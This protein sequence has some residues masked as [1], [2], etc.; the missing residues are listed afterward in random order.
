MNRTTK[1]PITPHTISVLMIVGVICAFVAAT[2]GNTATTY[3]ESRPGGNVTDSVVRAVD[4]A[5]PS[6]VRIITTVPGHLIVRFPQG[7]DVTFPQPNSQSKNLIN[8]NAYALQL[9][10]SGTFIT[11][12]GDIVTADHV[13]NPPQQDLAQFLD[14]VAAPD[15]ADYIN[16]NPKTGMAQTTP[17]QVLQQ[18]GSDTLKSTATFS[19]PASEV[20]LSTDYTGPL[21]APDFR[22]IPAEIHA[23]VDKIE[24]ESPIDQKDIAI[25]HAPFTDTPS[26]QLGDSS[27]VQQQDELTIIG[28]PGN[29]DVSNKPTD[30]LTSSVNRI[31]VSSIKSTDNGAP[32]IQVGGNVE[33][34]DS[35]G[36][37]LDSKGTVVGIVSFGLSSSNSIGGT[38]F[39]QASN[40]AR[41]FVQ[42]LNLDTTPGQFQKQ[43]S[44]A[45]TSYASNT[46]GHW[47]QAQLQ[48]TQL[49]SNYPQFKAIKPYMDYTATQAKTEKAVVQPTPRAAGAA[50]PPVQLPTTLSQIPAMAWTIGTVVV[51][52]L[53]SGLLFGVAVRQRKKKPD[54]N[55]PQA[56]VPSAVA[57]AAGHTAGHTHAPQAPQVQGQQVHPASPIGRGQ[58]VPPQPHDGMTAFGAPPSSTL[59]RPVP[60]VRPQQVP[61][62]MH[63]AANMPA[64]SANS[65]TFTAIRIWPCGH[66]NRPNARFCTICGEAAPPP[67]TSRHVEQ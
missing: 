12:K 57:S 37:A 15:V 35:G 2:F 60:P 40:G 38:S 9:S 42:S 55:K 56:A 5:K 10:G 52:V 20:F 41:D 13:I 24:K 21:S 62:P 23:T 67:S 17:G 28:F 6:V 30:L 46:P 59:Q 65:G 26:V 11:S 32:V 50:N 61:S 18:L 51:I 66:M 47:R 64:V 19:Q 25:V 48:F 22:S 7:G 3:A 63:P 58:A 14:K 4:I 43:W 1:K 53:L 16:A 33:Q 54:A 36:P 44:Q 39:L 8:G 27:S 49:A 34:G 31:S 45:F 29:G